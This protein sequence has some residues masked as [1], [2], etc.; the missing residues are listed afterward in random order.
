MYEL[1]IIAIIRVILQDHGSAIKSA[2]DVV[3]LYKSTPKYQNPKIDEFG[4][5]DTIGKHKIKGMSWKFIGG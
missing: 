1:Q 4:I 3:K 5:R 2:D